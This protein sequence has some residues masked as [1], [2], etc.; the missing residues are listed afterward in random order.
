VRNSDPPVLVVF[1]RQSE[2]GEC[3]E[4]NVKRSDKAWV[5]NKLAAGSAP[6]AL[7]HQ[8][9]KRGARVGRE[10]DTAVRQ[11]QA[12]LKLRALEQTHA[13]GVPENRGRV[14]CARGIPRE[15]RPISGVAIS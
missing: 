12:S 15:A 3:A 8:H 2:I 6:T 5:K 9:P 4:A 7:P 11:L 1:Q 13:G 10:L 14:L